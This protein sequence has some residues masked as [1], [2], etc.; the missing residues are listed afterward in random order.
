[1]YFYQFHICLW[2]SN[3]VTEE[4]DLKPESE[5]GRQLVIVEKLLQMNSRFK[6]TVLRFGGLIGE[7]R[8][9]Y[10]AGRKTS[11]TPMLPLISFIKRIVL[12]LS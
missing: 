12:E 9:P 1:M 11:T 3:N 10:I 8:N 4:T 6:T 5:G 7:D 2:G